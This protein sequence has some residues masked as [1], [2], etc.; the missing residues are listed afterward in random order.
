MTDS[1]GALSPDEQ[2]VAAAYQ[3]KLALDAARKEI[4]GFRLKEEDLL[5]RV[6][7]ANLEIVRLQREVEHLSKRTDL[8]ENMANE[9]AEA[10]LKNLE[11][12]DKIATLHQLAQQKEPIQ[13]TQRSSKGVG[14]FNDT[15]EGFAQTNEKVLPSPK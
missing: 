15:R 9:L 10:R 13:P 5:G 1:S 14:F 2:S 12:E 7:T 8:Y 11:L 4:A 3:T 6:R